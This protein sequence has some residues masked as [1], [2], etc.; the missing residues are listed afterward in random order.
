VSGVFTRL[1]AV[2]SGMPGV[3]STDEGAGENFGA[4]VFSPS[5]KL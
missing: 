3:L 5:N 2:L 1:Q 4:D